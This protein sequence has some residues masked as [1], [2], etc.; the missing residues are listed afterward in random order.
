M[1][2]G[3]LGKARSNPWIISTVVLAIVLVAILFFKLSPSGTVDKDTAAENLITFINSQGQGTAELVSVERSGQLYQ[4]NVQYQGNNIPV[5][6]TLDGDFL[7]SSVFPLSSGVGNGASEAGNEV[8]NVEVRDSPFKGSETAP[9]TIVEFSDY[10]CPF[11]SRFFS[12][13]LKLIDEN[14][15]KT[16]KVR[17]V[18]KDFPLSNIHPEAQKAAEAARCV[19]EQGGDESYFLMHDKL[20]ENQASLGIENYKKWAREIDGIDGDQFDECL[21]SDKHQ[22][23]V[24][25]DL[26]YGQSLGVRGT[27]YFFINGMKV[28]G[29][30]AYSVYKQ[31]IDLELGEQ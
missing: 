26:A 14:Y 18:Y 25:A 7:V 16:G 15:I 8:V 31:I 29:A 10:E 13:E 11:C 30:Q 23:G 2:K 28:E 24:L 20:F 6:V 5:L 1:K 19:R 12:Q 3:K 17:L 4:V 21:D 27:P 22:S 9:V